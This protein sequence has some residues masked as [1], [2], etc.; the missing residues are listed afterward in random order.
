M[1]E[2]ELHSALK[3]LS[4]EEVIFAADRAEEQDNLSRA[5]G[6][7]EDAV[8]WLSDIVANDNT[9]D[10]EPPSGKEITRWVEEW[11]HEA[12]KYLENTNKEE[13]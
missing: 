6:L 4:K 8:G 5:D 7:I 13:V 10:G 1:T 3:S 9:R 12:S 2:Q 11:L